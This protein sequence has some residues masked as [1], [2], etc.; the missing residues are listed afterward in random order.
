MKGFSPKDLRSTM[1]LLYPP[2]RKCCREEVRVQTRSRGNINSNISHC[3]RCLGMDT[4]TERVA[5][6]LVVKAGI[7]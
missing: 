1:L 4:V 7:A 3:V 2:I 5:N 6:A